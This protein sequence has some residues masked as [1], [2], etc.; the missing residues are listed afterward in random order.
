MKGKTIGNVIIVVLGGILITSI[1]LTINKLKSKDNNTAVITETTK[2]LRGIDEQ[3]LNDLEVKLQNTN[4][5]VA[6]EGIVEDAKVKFIDS[7]I[8]NSNDT[9]MN[10]L[11]KKL[12]EM[13]SRSLTINSTYKFSFT[14][15]LSDLKVVNSDNKAIINLHRSRLNL[16]SVELDNSKTSMSSDLGILS[17]VFSP[18]EVNSL[19]QRSKG[20]VS[21]TIRAN[22]T[23]RDKAMI[24]VR[25]NITNLCNE[26]N[27][28]V[29]VSIDELD[30]VEQNQYSEI[31]NIIIKGE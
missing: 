24:N 30:V 9:Q 18:N 19:Q 10:W 31:G 16:N 21:N 3:A 7:E 12:A 17:S 15:D 25:D 5:I 8:K 22:K 6:L 13:K 20:Y 29:D 4:K 2:E 1:A 28:D 26:L 11:S 27:V 14:Y 23:I